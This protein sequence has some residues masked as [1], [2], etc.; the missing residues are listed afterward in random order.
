MIIRRLLTFPFIFSVIILS[1]SAAFA[2]NTGGVF[3]PVVNKDHRVIQNRTTYNPKTDGL[4]SRL[5]FEQSLN[6][7]YMWRIVGQTR[8]TDDRTLDFDYVQGELFW[9]LTE[10]DQD[11][12]TG[13]RFDARIRSD[14]RPGFVGLNWMNQYAISD[15][16]SV[17][18]LVLTT[19]EIGEGARDGISLQT[20][21]N[22][23]YRYDETFSGGLE[24]FNSYGFTSDLNGFEDQSHQIGPFVNSRLGN[25]WTLFT[26]ALIGVTRASAD[27]ELRTWVTRRF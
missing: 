3:G 11:F 2:Q 26:G 21:S 9:Q 25:D 23:T 13:V 6:D 14:G 12:Q 5:H 22:V 18:G 17:R 16:L 24:F 19:L 1:A 7:D 20:R 10:N 8:K 27:R 4:T 15:H